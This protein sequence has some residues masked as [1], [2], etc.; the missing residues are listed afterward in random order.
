MGFRVSEPLAF[1][2]KVPCWNWRIALGQFGLVAG[3]GLACDAAGGRGTYD[4]RLRGSR[5]IRRSHPQ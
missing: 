4:W 2:V 3:E 1:S 5:L